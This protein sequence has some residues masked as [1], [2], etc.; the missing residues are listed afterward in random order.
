MMQKRDI[1]F[2]DLKRHYAAIKPRIDDAVLR[3]L[4]S[5]WYILGSELEKFEKEF[6][7]YVGSYYAVGVGSGTEA[8]H[9]ALVA[10][11]VQPGD[12]VIT[13][14]NT[15]VPT[16]SAISFA[17]AVPVFVEIDPD[18][19]CMDAT[20]LEDAITPKTKAIVPVHLYGHACDMPHIMDIAN[21]HN[22]KVIE[23][24][25]QAHGATVGGQK[26]GTFGDFGSF[27]FY[28]SKNLGAFGD[29]GMVVTN[30]AADAEALVK[31][32]N[33]GQSKRYYHDSLGFNS[34]LDELQAAILSTQ[35][36]SLPEWTARRRE[37]AR[38]FYKNI[39]NKNIFLPRVKD[40][41][42][43]VY[44]L[45]VVRHPNRDELRLHLSEH[46]IGSQIH[47][48]VPCHLQQAYDFLGVPKGRLPITENY[49]QT[50]LSLPNYPEL[51]DDEV[52]F[53]CDVLNKF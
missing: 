44:H 39:K 25:A 27:S 33:Y 26:V 29:A 30:D 2:G 40:G 53:I 36:E 11:G 17:Q 38:L 21:N 31:L 6:S 3:V 7:Q 20:R 45:F 32:R 43:H 37:I 35:L 51:T 19:Y 24:C 50:V 18:S 49:A 22:L 42:E 10:A 48:P 5:G 4:E 34:R 23:D 15:A 28:P 46:G 16:L 47:Y 13:V 12:N 9:L 14:A 41:V 8:L 52:L 1:P